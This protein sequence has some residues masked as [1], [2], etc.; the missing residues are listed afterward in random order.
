ML[1][2]RLGENSPG[3]ELPANL[4]EVIEPLCLDEGSSAAARFL[5]AQSLG[6]WVPA[7]D[8]PE[9]RAALASPLRRLDLTRCSLRG[10]LS[11]V[12]GLT[13]LAALVLDD[14]A[15]SGPLP[16]ALTALR[17]LA[18][19]SAERNQLTG[20]LPACYCTLRAELR[21]LRL[22]SN[23]LDGPIPP[24]WGQLD[25]LEELGLG[26][27]KGVDALRDGWIAS[28]LPTCLVTF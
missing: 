13:S 4:S 18:L 14:N 28:R 7:A 6:V 20:P 17:A 9:K 10:P 12:G 11:A 24:E 2:L 25:H 27:N 15:L 3:F 16:E 26:R 19:F 5:S 8:T 1:D 21:A 22:C 23:R